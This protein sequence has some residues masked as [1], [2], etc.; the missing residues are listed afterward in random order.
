[1]YRQKAEIFLS[2]MVFLLYLSVFQNVYPG[3]F[4][5]P[6]SQHVLLRRTSRRTDSQSNHWL[7]IQD[8]RAGYQDCSADVF[9]N[10]DKHF[11]NVVAASDKRKRKNMNCWIWP[12]GDVSLIILSRN[13][14]KRNI[15]I[16][17]K[18]I[19]SLWFFDLWI[20]VSTFRNFYVNAADHVT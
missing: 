8:T 1:M 2:W 16:A 10:T 5:P 15:Q 20:P 7:V 4:N 14:H 3:Q 9:K 13:H 19:S 11:T 12:R 17:E 18:N 6:T